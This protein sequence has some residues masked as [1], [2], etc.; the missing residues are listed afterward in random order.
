MTRVGV[1]LGSV[2]DPTENIERV[3]HDWGK[4]LD[5]AIELEAFGSAPVPETARDY[6]TKQKTRERTAKTPFG[7]VLNSYRD[8]IEYITTHEPDVILSIWKYHIHAPGVA[9]AGWQSNIPTVT[10]ITGDVYNEYQHYQGLKRAGA[11]LLDNIIGSLPPKL[12]NKMIA[13]GPFEQQEVINRGISADDVV[14]LPPPKPASNNFSKPC[15]KEN[16]QKEINLPRNTPIAL[17][18]GRISDEKG[19]P[20]LAEVIRFV[21]S[22]QNMR[23]IL[24]GEGPCKQY[25]KKEFGEFVILPG[26]VPHNRIHLYYKAADMYVHPSA[27]EG[28]PLVILEALSCGLPVVAR[29]AGDIPFILDDSDIAT[30]PQEMAEWILDWPNSSNWNNMEYFTDQYQRQT[31]QDLF[32]NI[33]QD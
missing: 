27:Y 18:V 22:Q 3:L 33:D 28:V 29:L 17:F 10:R 12:S 13:L 31:L 16:Y 14:L 20:F 4:Y 9:V 30:Q 11:Y 24:V 15:D 2:N 21:L 1:Y 32:L 8:S 26:Q 6:F 5:D 19:M 25:L 23:F 7:K